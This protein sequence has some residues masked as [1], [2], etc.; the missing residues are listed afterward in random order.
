MD[1]Y[2][3]H[4]NFYNDPGDNNNT[5]ETYYAVSVDGQFSHISLDP[6]AARD[7][8]DE[9]EKDAHIS[10]TEV[11]SEVVLAEV[12]IPSQIKILKTNC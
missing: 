4:I 2:P 12:F 8:Y 7:Y 5:T 11:S 10:D 9:A 6:A 1:N 3:P